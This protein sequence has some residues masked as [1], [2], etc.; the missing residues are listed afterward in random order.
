M[1]TYSD[2]RDKER[3]PLVK[4]VARREVVCRGEGEWCWDGVLPFE[5]II[6]EGEAR[7]VEDEA[8]DIILQS[9]WL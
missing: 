6:A 5:M 4:K 3:H 2:G 9:L 7:I 1:R 8:V